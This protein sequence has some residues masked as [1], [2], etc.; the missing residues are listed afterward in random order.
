M[1]GE[2]DDDRADMLRLKDGDDLALNEL[3][4]RWQKPLAA[5]IQR[6]TGNAEDALDLAQETFV[7]VDGSRH[8][9]QPTARSRGG[10]SPSRRDARD[11]TGVSA[12]AT[13]RPRREHPLLSARLSTTPKFHTV[14]M[15]A[16]PARVGSRKHAAGAG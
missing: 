6:Y 5:F 16:L 3:M 9:Y 7:R 14:V 12:C 2:L 4:T 10:C 8:R 1:I 13:P 15:F 11:T